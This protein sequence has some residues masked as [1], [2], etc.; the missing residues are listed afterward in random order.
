MR[1]NRCR[2]VISGT[3]CEVE[4]GFFE[5]YAPSVLVLT[6]SYHLTLRPPPLP[7][8]PNK[9][10]RKEKTRQPTTEVLAAFIIYLQ[11]NSE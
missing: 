9:K 3:V 6:F 7:P 10:K 5:R 2:R 11:R 4:F 1:Q 8:S